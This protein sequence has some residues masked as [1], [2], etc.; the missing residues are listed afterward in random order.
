MHL[1]RD[2][3]RCRFDCDV[4]VDGEREREREREDTGSLVPKAADDL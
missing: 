1:Y 4:D 3:L 2:G